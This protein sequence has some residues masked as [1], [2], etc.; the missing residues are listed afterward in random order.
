MDHIT[1]ERKPRRSASFLSEIAKANALTSDM[2]QRYAP[3]ALPE[4]C[5]D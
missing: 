3:E 5:A 2:V 4:I 1:Q